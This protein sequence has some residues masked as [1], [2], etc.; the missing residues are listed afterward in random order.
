MEAFLVCLFNKITFQNV[1]KGIN[2]MCFSYKEQIRN[3]KLYRKCVKNDIPG[4]G[5]VA[6]W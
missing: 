4:A 5:V 6:Q 2:Y 3:I 1:W